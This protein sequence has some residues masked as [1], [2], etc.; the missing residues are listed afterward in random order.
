MAVWTWIL[1]KN[2]CSFVFKAV[3]YLRPS[4][5]APRVD[6][7]DINIPRYSVHQPMDK[8]TVYRGGFF[9][10]LAQIPTCPTLVGTLLA[11]L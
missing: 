2:F 4:L 10:V 6:I 8:D 3:K 7:K 1:L 5:S 11:I 9:H